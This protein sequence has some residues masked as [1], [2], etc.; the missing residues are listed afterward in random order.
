[1]A[2]LAK[3]R[4]AHRQAFVNEKTVELDGHRQRKGQAHRHAH[5]IVLHRFAQVDAE[6]GELLDK[7][8]QRL[9]V[10]AIDAADEFQVV[11]AG[12]VGLESARESQ[13]PAHAHATFDAPA[14]GP[15]GA[16]EQADERALAGAIAAQDAHVAAALQVEAQMVQ[17]LPAPEAGA[18]GLAHPVQADQG[19]SARLP[20]SRST[21]NPNRVSTRLTKPM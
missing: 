20:A 5:G 6:L 2:A 19:A 15:F 7:G 11:E 14:G 10:L 4:I 8:H 1:M 18:V 13:R 12:Q 17:H 21:H 3:A 16:A 9:P